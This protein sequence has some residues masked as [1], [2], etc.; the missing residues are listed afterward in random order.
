MNVFEL[1][2]TIAIDHSQASSALAKVGK[3]AKATG[4]AI[5]DAFS[6]IGSASVKVGKVVAGA[7]AAVGG[8]W[9]A[10]IEGTRDYR[11]ALAKL[12]TAFVTNGHSAETA[13]KTYQDLQSVLGETDV[14]VEAANHLAVMCDNEEELQKWT[15]ICT[16]VFAVFGDSL[17]IEGLTEAANETAKVGQ[18][19]GTLADALNWAGISEEDFNTKLR[20]CRTEQERQQLILNHLNHAYKNSSDH[21]KKNAED[22][23]KANRAQESWNSAMA[24]LGAIGEPILTSIKQKTADMVLAAVPHLENFITKFKE[25]ENV[26]TDVIWP[27][28]QST[29]KVAFGIDVPEWSVVES[30]VTT[31]WTETAKPALEQKFKAT[32][33]IDPP[34]WATIP[35]TIQTWW[36]NTAKPK[37]EET[38]KAIME[39]KPPDLTGLASA[40]DVDWTKFVM[41][42][43]TG[44]LTGNMLTITPVIGL[45]LA[46]LITSNWDTH[47]A[48][49]L[50]GFLN[51]DLNITTPDFAALADTIVK[52]WDTYVSPDVKEMFT[53]LGSSLSEALGTGGET[54]AYVLNGVKDFGTWCAENKDTVAGFFT[55]ISGKAVDDAGNLLTITADAIK[56][57]TAIGTDA[58]TGALQWIMSN[59]ETVAFALEAMA[60]G[61]LTASIAAHPLA[62]AIVATAATLG[63]LREYANDDMYDSFFEGHDPEALA[64]L[65]EWVEA[66]RALKEADDTYQM[67]VSDE[68]Y[69]ALVDAADAAAQ[70]VNELDGALIG[71]YNEWRSGQENP[72]EY[73]DIPMR[74]ADDAQEVIQGDLDGMTFESEVG[75]KA[76][77]SAIWSALRNAGFT[78]YATIFPDYSQGNSISGGQAATQRTF[79]SHAKGLDFVPRDGYLARLHY[80]E[81]VLNRTTADMLRSGSGM[82]NTGNLEAMLGQ[83]LTLTQQMVANTAGGQKVVLDSGAVV[84]QLAP[85]MDARLGT[86]SSRKGRGN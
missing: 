47:I 13:K 51:Q 86:I 60:V 58:V 25:I 48:P 85:M 3:N 9:V 32:F 71:L 56:G 37:I 53:S 7:G 34:D 10:A 12:D 40:F 67:N 57:F 69:D 52:D 31:W 80:G 83:L 44:L 16:G 62:A 79:T 50:A 24:A 59:G 5:Q 17:P 72:L 63:L 35:A 82:G 4:K 75:M 28:M 18:V 11:T 76:D 78:A 26:W 74:A 23:I 29:F 1:F 19:T 36:T 61:F 64:A 30:T 22:I 45:G 77:T 54:F 65:Q 42:T 27:L 33:G 43:L 21:Y 55:T 15:D 2:G 41:P 8:A 66:K 81:A 6:K 20:A 14:A 38:A 46:G 68:E 49:V 70:K 39:I 84:G 73:L